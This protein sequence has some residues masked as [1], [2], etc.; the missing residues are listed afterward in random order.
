MS[1]SY[2]FCSLSPPILSIWNNLAL[3]TVAEFEQLVAFRVAFVVDNLV[4]L[5]NSDISVKEYYGPLPEDTCSGIPCL[6]NIVLSLITIT[7]DVS[8]S[9]ADISINL[10]K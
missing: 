8:L 7:C 2:L 5:A 4:T 6:I 9:S 1:Q 10:E 3:L